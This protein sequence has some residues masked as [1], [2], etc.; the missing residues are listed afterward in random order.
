MNTKKKPGKMTMIA[1]PRDSAVTDRPANQRTL[2]SYRTD[3]EWVVEA[4]DEAGRWLFT[5]FGS[6]PMSRAQAV[7]LAK[8]W[9]PQT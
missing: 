7:K 1:R 2:E 8:N 9:V 4:I 3:C 6:E 5:H